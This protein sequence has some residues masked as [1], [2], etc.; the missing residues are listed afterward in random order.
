MFSSRKTGSASNAYNLTNSLRFRSS[1]SAYLN[2]TPASAGNRRTFTISV[3]VKR[4]KLGSPQPILVGFNGGSQYT[5]IG[6]NGSDQIYIPQDNGSGGVFYPNTNAVFRD[7]SAWYHIVVAFD[8]TQGTDTNRLKVYVNNVQQT[9]TGGAIYPSQNSDTWINIANTHYLGGWTTVSE[10]TDGY[11]AE[12]NFIDGQ[13]LTPSSFGQTSATTGVW[14]PIKYTGTYGT[15]GFYLPFTNTTSTS[16]LGN[17]FSG[18]GNTW[19]VNNISL[20]AGTTYDSMT[21]VPTL[22]SATAAN[23]CVLNP[24]DKN[25]SSITISN[26]NLQYATTSTNFGVRA[27]VG[28]SSGKW[29]W[30]ANITTKTNEIIIGIAN[31]AWGLTY[32]GSTSGSYGYGA[33]GAKYNNTTANS[34][35]A[36]FTTGDVI[37]VALDLDA[38]TLMFYK[39][40]S[41]QGTAYSSISGTF[42]PACSGQTS[43]TVNV[44]FGQR[45]FAYT[46]PTGF[47]R[48]NTFNLSTPTIGATASTQANKYFDATLYTGTGSSL[49]ITNSNSMQ[50]DFVWIKSRSGATDHGLYDA[51]RG[52][53][54]QLESN[55]TGAETTETT[56]L[57]AFNSNGFTVGAL[58]Q[59]NTNTATYVAWQ[60][61][62]SNAT[63]VS[64][65][66]GSITS[67]VSA[68]TTAGFSIVTYTGTGALATVGHGLGVAPSWVIIKK[69]SSATNSNW[70]IGNSAS[71]W[72]GQL[73][74]DTGAFST[75]SGS[76]NNT[77]PT[78]SV[79][80]INTDSTVNA[81]TATYVAYCFAQV[82]GYSA[83]GSYTGNGS[84]DGPF[85]FTGFRPRWVM[86]KKSSSTGNWLIFDTARSTFN[87]QD[88]ALF[89][90]LANAE[91]ASTNYN[92]DFVSNG[93]KVRTLDG[94][95]NDSG[96]TYIYAAFAESPFKYANAR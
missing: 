24:L 88:D 33:S 61:R 90:N 89:P 8:T 16:T 4:A 42:F 82:S 32:V 45:P 58:A 53:Q 64:N 10:Y 41:S 63:G 73:Y 46:P 37:G 43:D 80:T 36:S 93:F 3:W 20:T 35:G 19:T 59:L 70:V 21:D 57:T 5:S 28:V 74:F 34:Y 39:N 84:T 47:N 94:S 83:F 60:W 13:A 75:N 40:N 44:N 62:A 52:V 96:V 27:T 56:G 23:Y 86:V 69:R 14:Q 17:D 26:G 9:L 6:F 76:F 30:E 81:S 2:R 31:A 1:A 72:T 85:I 12:Y 65:T 7:P 71:G 54:L 78:S 87:V 38:G 67:T 55:N 91:T 77:A 68:N 48:L 29:Y 11:F 66:S 50:P 92:N 95:W 15:N 49:S 25:T 79:F 22:T 51:V 18:N